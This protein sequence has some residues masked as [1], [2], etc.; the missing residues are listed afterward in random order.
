[1]DDEESLR[2]LGKAI[3]S[4]FGYT[5]LAASEG[6]GALEIYRGEKERV[7]L[8]ILDLIM[9]EVGGLRCLEELLRINPDVKVVIATGYYP[10][11]SVKAVLEGEGRGFISK[12]YDMSE[13]LRVVRK[14]LDK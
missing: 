3:L 4:T 8:I 13:M 12:P 1:M 6:E 14:V 5:V 2:D 9:P 7:H 11:D 10:E